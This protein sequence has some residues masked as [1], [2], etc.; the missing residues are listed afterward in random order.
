[1]PG[2]H[3][4]QQIAAAVQDCHSKL[5]AVHCNT[6]TVPLVWNTRRVARC[7]QLQFT[8]HY[9]GR[10]QQWLATECSSTANRQA[11]YT[12]SC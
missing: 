3:Q 1:M 11:V 12:A 9:C 8:P 10:S 7:W 6:S 2:N 5:C 4:Q